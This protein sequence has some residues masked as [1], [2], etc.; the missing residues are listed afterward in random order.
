MK[1]IHATPL[2]LLIVSTSAWSTSTWAADPNWYVVGEVTHSRTNLDTGTNDTALAQAG[3]TGIT[4][5]GKSHSNRWRLQ[6]GYQFNPNFAVEG[7][8]ID[9]GKAK[10]TATY[11]GGT[12]TGEVKSGGIDIAALGILPLGQGFSVFG[13]AGLVVARTKST[14]TATG[15][16]SAATYERSANTVSPLVGVGATYRITRNVDL[17]AEYDYANRLGTTDKTGRVK[18]N[19]FSVGVAYHF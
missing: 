3:A 2:A 1:L 17:R 14:L 18:A 5:D 7:G 19:M 6:L 10:Y 9:F 13:K 15:A 4:S 8:Y 11:S 12:A 16:A